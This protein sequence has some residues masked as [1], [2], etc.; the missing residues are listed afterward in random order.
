MNTCKDD[1][2]QVLEDDLNGF[3]VWDTKEKVAWA[4][5]LQERHFAHIIA[6]KLNGY[7]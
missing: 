4:W 7:A 3:K 5:G 6:S 1:R 2:Y